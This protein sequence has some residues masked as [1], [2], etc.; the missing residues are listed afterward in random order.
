MSLERKFIRILD[1]DRSTDYR[2][3]GSDVIETYE[4]PNVDVATHLATLRAATFTGFG[5]TALP[6][7]EIGAKEHT[8]ANGRHRRNV[9]S[10]E[11]KY[12]NKFSG[13]NGAVLRRT[14]NL[15]RAVVRIVPVMSKARIPVIAGNLLWE[16]FPEGTGAA[17]TVYRWVPA[18]EDDERFWLDS[19][20]ALVTVECAVLLASGLVATWMALI[21]K[22]NAAACARLG[23]AGAKNLLM[24]APE[25]QVEAGDTVALA[26][27]NLVYSSQG[28]D[29]VEVDKEVIEIVNVGVS[30]ETPV[31]PV[32]VWA[33]VGG[34]ATPI[35]FTEGD[36]TAINALAYWYTT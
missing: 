20:F 1:E 7:R 13:G 16:L 9:A 3:M 25:I 2:R 30:G 14:E 8:D 28:W 32:P 29:S 6:C 5:L 22:I 4:C 18:N 11:V 19:R 15:G 12:S 10:I 36:F 23:N 33:K 34:A 35:T 24:L 27:I 26:R 31:V 17:R 21:G